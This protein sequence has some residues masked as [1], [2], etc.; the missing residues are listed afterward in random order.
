M[1]LAFL[2]AVQL[3]AGIRALPVDRVVNLAARASNANISIPST[4]IASVITSI[5]N[6]TSVIP[7]D[8]PL[9]SSIADAIVA[10][11]SFLPCWTTVNYNQVTVG[12]GIGDSAVFRG[13][14][15]PTT[16]N[17]VGLNNIVFY[18]DGGALPFASTLPAVYAFN[19]AVKNTTISTT[20]YGTGYQ[21]VFGLASTVTSHNFGLILFDKMTL[22]LVVFNAKTSETLFSTV[23]TFAKPKLGINPKSFVVGNVVSSLIANPSKRYDPTTCGGA[24]YL[25]LGNNWQV[26]LPYSSNGDPGITAITNPAFQ[27][28]AS[29]YFY[30]NTTRRA[31]V[32][33]TANT[34]VTTPGSSSPRT[35]LR[36]MV[37]SSDGTDPAVWS[38]STSHKLSVRLQVDYVP[39]GEFVIFAQIV[40]I[41]NGAY[42]TYRVAPINNQP[43]LQVLACAAGY[44]C[45]IVDPDYELGTLITVSISVS[46]NTVTSTYTNAVS[47]TINGP[48]L[49]ALPAYTDLAFKLGS[50]CGI[51][52]TDPAT[53][54]CQVSV[55]SVSVV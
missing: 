42:F 54:Y 26:Q 36:Q 6:D 13:A 7:P 40:S 38:S 21:V 24:A 1:L 52:I 53:H 51:T 11:Q 44:P 4:D 31:V 37:A 16:K 5:A 49:F 47:G 12:L 30:V 33:Y 19:A 55:F 46:K 25:K 10:G 2:Y 29:P 9:Q 39:V 27:S 43:G 17:P 32:F 3:I 48:F 35:E 22:V 34:G 14:K 45:L 28:F 20:P 41:A 50:Y 18:V 23:F 15:I 8:D